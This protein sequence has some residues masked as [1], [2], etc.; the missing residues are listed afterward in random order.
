[1]FGTAISCASSQ[2]K[3]NIV[4]QMDTQKKKKKENKSSKNSKNN[5][6]GS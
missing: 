4:H 3:W 1:M 2:H 6:L 5:K